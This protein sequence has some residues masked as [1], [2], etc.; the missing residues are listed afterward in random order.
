GHAVSYATVATLLHD[1]EYSLQANRKTQAGRGHPDRDAQFVYIDKQVRAFQR[2]GQP[3][4]SVD[5]KKREL[6]GDFKNSGREWR[7]RG[8]PE[9]VKVYAYPDKELGKVTPGGVY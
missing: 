2:E 4:I 7:P 5:S 8:T 1:L 3:V 9:K 6:I